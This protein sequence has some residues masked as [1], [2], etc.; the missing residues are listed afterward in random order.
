MLFPSNSLEI[1][2]SPGERK[3]VRVSFWHEWHRQSSIQ[4]GKIVR[5]SRLLRAFFSLMGRPDGRAH[6]NRLG[7]GYPWKNNH[8]HKQPASL[9][10]DRRFQIHSASQSGE[11]GPS[12]RHIPVW[13]YSQILPTKIEVRIF[14]SLDHPTPYRL[15]RIAANPSWRQPCA[16]TRWLQLA[17]TA[18]VFICQG[19]NADSQSYRSISL[20]RYCDI[21]STP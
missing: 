19:K 16:D 10:D 1:L 5:V 4:G 15:F 8:H 2:C 13:N 12:Y 3:I 21:S 14:D 18:R 7:F 20:A 11:V 9:Q 6:R 17:F